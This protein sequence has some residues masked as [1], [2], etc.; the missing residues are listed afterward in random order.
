VGRFHLSIVGLGLA[1]A[2]LTPGIALA[3]SGNQYLINGYVNG[4][5]VQWTVQDQQRQDA[6]FAQI[7]QRIG[8]SP[9]TGTSP[10]IGGLPPQ[11][12][13]TPIGTGDWLSSDYLQDTSESTAPGAKDSY[14]ILET[15]GS[16]TCGP[17]AA[18]NLLTDFGP[19]LNYTQLESEVGYVHGPGTGWTSQYWSALNQNQSLYTYQG[20]WENAT[21]TSTAWQDGFYVVVS[22]VGVNYRPTAV[23]AAGQLPGFDHSVNHWFVGFGYS[24]YTTTST[25]ST[26]YLHYFDSSEDH[27]GQYWFN[28]VLSTFVG[29]DDLYGVVG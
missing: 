12:Y 22:T 1:L 3:D 7:L 8:R 27:L 5:L 16:D 17:I 20:Y 15:K 6:A 26:E 24:G 2:L 23:N 29:T 13:D 11:T 14:L 4:E 28:V 25:P 18:H 9:T 19:A 21:Y 10:Y